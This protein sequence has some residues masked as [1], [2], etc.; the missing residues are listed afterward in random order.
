LNKLQNDTNITIRNIS[1]F[2]SFKMKITKYSLATENDDILNNR[3][4]KDVSEVSFVI[5]VDQKNY[6][7]PTMY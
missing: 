3:A 1:D 6:E 2:F 4:D 7:D 5:C